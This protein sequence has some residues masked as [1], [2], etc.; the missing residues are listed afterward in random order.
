MVNLI[1][2]NKYGFVLNFCNIVHNTKINF[3]YKNEHIL[4]RKNI[5]TQNN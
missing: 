1:K 2:Y 4:F 3:L 5:F